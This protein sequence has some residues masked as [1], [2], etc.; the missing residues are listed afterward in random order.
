MLW[1]LGDKNYVLGVYIFII[2]LRT[3]KKAD[4]II[5][6]MIGQSI[7]GTSSRGN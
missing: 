7:K 4:D 3:F 2:F 6:S 1:G 5:S